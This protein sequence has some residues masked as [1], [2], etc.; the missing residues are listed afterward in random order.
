MNHKVTLDLHFG[1]ED[2]DIWQVLQEFPQ[3]E[4]E[5]II[6][7]ALKIWSAEQGIREINL[8]D[9][10]NS[11]VGTEESEVSARDKATFGENSTVSSQVS[12]HLED[13]FSPTSPDLSSSKTSLAE[14]FPEPGFPLETKPD[15]L[16]HLFALIGEE[17]DEDVLKLLQGKPS[18]LTKDKGQREASVSKEQ[19]PLAIEPNLSYIVLNQL[20]REINSS[21]KVLQP[22]E[23]EPKAP[24]K[25]TYPDSLSGNSALTNK[26]L[27][28][29]LQNVIGEEDDPEVL[30]YF[31][32]QK[33]EKQS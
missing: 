15:P 14:S 32:N 10:G 12:W 24:E 30:K 18:P 22:A 3:E 7:E 25:E 6:K 4:W 2:Q 21:E 20:D 27:N 5:K 23:N 19:V 8:Q 17:E 11:Q 29:I 26:G 13:L 28:Y 31:K 1:K 16:R 9:Q 33:D